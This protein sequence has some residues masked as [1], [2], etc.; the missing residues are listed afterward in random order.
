MAFKNAH[1]ISTI[2]LNYHR[3]SFPSLYWPINPLPSQTHYLYYPTDIWRFTLFWTLISYVVCFGI[4]GVWGWGMVATGSSPPAGGG[5]NK[6][7]QRATTPRDRVEGGVEDGAWSVRSG[8]GTARNGGA[9]GK[10]W[11]VSVGSDWWYGAGWLVMVMIVGGVEAVVGGSV[12]GLILAAVYNAGYFR[13]STW[14]PCVWGVINTLVLVL[15][16]FSLQGGL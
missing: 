5:V 2:P 16:S 7:K 10:W 6:G 11:D 14:I 15:S 3:P 1:L 4:V 13:M 12:V 8:T 9:S